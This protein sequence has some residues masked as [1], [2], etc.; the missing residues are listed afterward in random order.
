MDFDAKL[1]GFKEFADGLRKLP[2]NIGKNVLR[3]AVS[4]GATVVRVEARNNAL[5]I[6]ETGTLARSIYQK[7]IRELS[8]PKNQV[9]FVGARSGKQ[10]KSTGKKGASKDA[11][12]AR[13]VEL[14]HFT[15]APG[16]R[17]RGTGRG[18]ANNAK[19]VQL[20][21]SG[22]VHWVPAKPF[23]RPA[24]DVKKEQAVDAM[25]ASIGLSLLTEAERSGMTGGK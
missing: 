3:R 8:G 22:H 2:E 14:G 20:V 1:E 7:Q 16:G 19:L 9:F 17:L 6:K 24:F 18:Q 4:A 5:A 23:L 25:G 21:Q 13:W 12:Y 11:Y 15:R 10:Y